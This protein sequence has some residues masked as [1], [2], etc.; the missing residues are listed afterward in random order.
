MLGNFENQE[1]WSYIV[2]QPA[3]RLR[4]G[5]IIKFNGEHCRVTDVEHVTPGK[6][7]GHVQAKMKNIN[8][9]SNVSHRFRSDEKFEKIFLEKK[10]MQYLYSG[11]NEHIFMDT[12]TYDQITLDDEALGHGKYYLIPDL[13]IEIEYLES[14]PVGVELPHTVE[15]TISETVPHIKGSTASSSYKPATLESGLVIQVPPFIEIGQKIKVDTREDKY[16]S[17]VD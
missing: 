17:K 5:M 3:T 8:T 11:D 1:G 12:E 10:K 9:G 6:G 14:Q 15:L 13:E 4:T 7:P 2:L 16:L